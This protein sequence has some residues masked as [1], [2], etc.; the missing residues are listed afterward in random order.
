MG[1]SLKQQQ[2]S[3]RKPKPLPNSLNHFNET[4]RSYCLDMCEREKL[5]RWQ[6]QHTQLQQ[7]YNFEENFLRVFFAIGSLTRRNVKNRSDS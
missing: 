4:N 1:K 5:M 7:V 6:H 3:G 2:R